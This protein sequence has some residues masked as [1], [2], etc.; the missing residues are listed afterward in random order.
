MD[1]PDVSRRDVPQRLGTLSLEK[2]RGMLGHV[3]EQSLLLLRHLAKF[4][5]A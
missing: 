1:A 2:L 3:A 4:E 5:S